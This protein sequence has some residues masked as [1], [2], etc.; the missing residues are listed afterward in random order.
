MQ[1]DIRKR[2]LTR[3]FNVVDTNGDGVF[4][5]QDT[6]LV[7]VRVAALRGLK[8]GTEGYQVFYQGFSYYWDD[9]RRSCS[10]S[11]SG[12]VTLQEWFDY[13]ATM[14]ADRERFEATAEASAALM[15]ALADTNDDGL[16]SLEEY[17]NWMRAWGMADGET[18]GSVLEKLD[19]RG[20]GQLTR[21]DVL[22]LTR[23]FFY[24]DD[25]QAPGNWAMGPF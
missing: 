3:F 7:A 19:R 25:P 2:K 12:Q 24:S 11:D 10:P 9:L 4:D 23:E 21:E 18:A 17:G 13:H 20:A 8:P 15:F 6:D 1:S 22:E 14:L 16:L 5:Q